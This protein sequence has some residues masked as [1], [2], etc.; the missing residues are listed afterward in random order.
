MLQSTEEHI[1]NDRES[2][3]EYEVIIAN[4]SAP[5]KGYPSKTKIDI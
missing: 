1:E 4:L 3:L 5:K 2:K